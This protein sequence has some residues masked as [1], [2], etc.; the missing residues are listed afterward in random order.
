MEGEMGKGCWRVFCGRID[1][2]KR[3]AKLNRDPDNSVEAWNEI[4]FSFAA[5][6]PALVTIFTER[7][8]TRIDI[9]LYAPSSLFSGCIS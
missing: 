2:T 6:G 3:S 1:I 8:S 5:K 4:I 9:P 7:D